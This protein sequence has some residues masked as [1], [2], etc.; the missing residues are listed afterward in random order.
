MLISLMRPSRSSWLSMSHPGSWVGTFTATLQPKHSPLYTVP[1]VPHPKAYRSFTSFSS[2]SRQLQGNIIFIFVS[3]TEAPVLLILASGAPATCVV[4]V[5][6]WFASRQHK[7]WVHKLALV[8]FFLFPP[9]RWGRRLKLKGIL[10]KG[11]G[12]KRTHPP[13]ATWGWSALV[14]LTCGM[15]RHRKFSS[16]DRFV[17]L[18][19]TTGGN[20][21]ALAPAVVRSCW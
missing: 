18:I 2:I 13:P 9:W 14:K 10:W 6:R 12:R 3:W 20:R 15:C 1:K 16:I 4:C 17:I 19:G 21:C 8:S 11:G 5:W 7:K